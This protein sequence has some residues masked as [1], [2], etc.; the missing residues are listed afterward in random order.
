MLIRRKIPGLK[1]TAWKIPNFVF[2][3]TTLTLNKDTAITIWCL[4]GGD[5]NGSLTKANLAI[6]EERRS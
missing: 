1:D 5:I 6:S 3:D 2:T 4:A